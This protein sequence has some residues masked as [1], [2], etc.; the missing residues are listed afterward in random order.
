VLARGLCRIAATASGSKVTPLGLCLST[1]LTF[2]VSSGRNPASAMRKSVAAQVTRSSRVP[3]GS[4]IRVGGRLGART[5]VPNSS[6]SPQ[7]NI[8]KV[9]TY[10]VY[11]QKHNVLCTVPWFSCLKTRYA[12]SIWLLSQGSPLVDLSMLIS[13]TASI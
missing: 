6:Q 5:V 2:V 3:S 4:P 1:S 12:S 13:S 11:Q 8:L 10:L 9:S 7:L